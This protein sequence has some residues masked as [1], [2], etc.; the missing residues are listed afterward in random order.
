MAVAYPPLMPTAF[1]RDLQDRGIKVL[2]VPYE[3]FLHTQGTNV[4]AV[5][6]GRL[7]MLDSNPV[8]QKMLLDAGCEVRTF[9]GAELSFKTEGGPS[10]LTRPVLRD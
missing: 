7:I 10:C 2:E 9:P 4:L 1:W 8:T 5:E 6:P 3:E